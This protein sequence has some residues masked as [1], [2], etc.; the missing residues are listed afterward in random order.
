MRCNL[1]YSALN[2]GNLQ[3]TVPFTI[4]PD[5]HPRKGAKMLPIWI[6]CAA[7]QPYIMVLGTDYAPYTLPSLEQHHQMAYAMFVRV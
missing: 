6:C 7:A 4:I 2:L 1:R 3:T 5:A